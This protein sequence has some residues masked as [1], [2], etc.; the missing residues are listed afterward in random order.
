[1]NFNVKNEFNIV[2][3]NHDTTRRRQR[4][5][6]HVTVCSSLCT[7]LRLSR[8]HRHPRP[9]PGDNACLACAARGAE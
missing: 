6:Q 5:W 4:R 1:V 3:G 7:K 2:S 9:T 8:C